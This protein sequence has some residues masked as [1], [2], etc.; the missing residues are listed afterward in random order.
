VNISYRGGVPDAPR[1]S[2]TAVI[3]GAS[4]GIGAATAQALHTAGFEVV[5]AARRQ[6]RIDA[7]AAE[8][9]DRAR[10]IACDVTDPGAVS[11]LAASVPSCAVLVVNAGGALG[12]EPVAEFDES[13]WQTMWETNVLGAART[14]RRFLPALE[15]SGDGRIV[16]VTSVAA[17]Q[18]YPGGGGYTAAKHA[19]AAITDTLRV[20]LL[21]KPIRVIEIAPGVVETE[22]STVRFDGDEARAAAVYEGLVPLTAEDVADAIVWAVT[23]PA[24][25]VVARMDL[26]PR[27]QANARDLSRN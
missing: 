25:M 23:R 9:N 16:V 13:K 4:S 3:T 1:T 20:E 2:A 26:F 17:H 6:D 11:S 15:A 22:F 27:D 24:H 19:A 8:L 18:T 7:L 5:L 10:A 14:I 21:G 12:L